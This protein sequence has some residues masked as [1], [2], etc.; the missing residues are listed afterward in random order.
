M[1]AKRH[2]DQHAANWDEKP[3]RVELASQICTCFL[4]QVDLNSGMEVL[5]FGCGTGLASL[6]WAGQVKMLT[7]LD[8]SPIMLDVFMGKANRQGLTNVRT[9]EVDPNEEDEDLPG[10]YDL[11][12]SSMVFHHIEDIEVLLGRLHGVLRPG[13]RLVVADLDPDGGLFHSSSEGIFHDG[14]DREA[15]RRMWEKFG[16]CEVRTTLATQF[17]KRVASTNEERGFSI[18]LMDGHK[19]G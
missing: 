4:E 13:G 19:V 11:V 9:V 2:F 5:D 3:E 16:F 12:L 10:P 6:P 14:F 15:L 1:D 7:G 18:F 8:P 17:V